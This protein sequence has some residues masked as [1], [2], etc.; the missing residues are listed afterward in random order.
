MAFHVVSYKI[1]NNV[2]NTFRR[3]HCQRFAR[4]SVKLHK[5][6]NIQ[7]FR[8]WLKEKRNKA[9]AVLKTITQQFETNTYNDNQ[10]QHSTNQIGGENAFKQPHNHRFDKL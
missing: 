3:S 6:H 4:T 7:L 5:M 9:N 1:P 8:I 2:F 10:S